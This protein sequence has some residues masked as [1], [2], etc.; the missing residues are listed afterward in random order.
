MRNELLLGLALALDIGTAN[1][2]PVP[3]GPGTPPVT[4]DGLSTCLTGNVLS[5][6]TT[7]TLSPFVFG[8]SATLNTK[9]ALTISGSFMHNLSVKASGSTASTITAPGGTL[10][11]EPTAT[12]SSVAVSTNAVAGRETCV[13]N[14]E[15]ATTVTLTSTTGSFF[16]HSAT[17]VAS[18][19]L[20]PGAVD[21]FESDGTN[22]Y[23]IP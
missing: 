19:T 15:T 23:Q 1:A 21:C 16:A 13:A 3:V 8:A 4:A 22:H 17:G 9:G 11:L 5:N 10:V 20:A 2:Q 7:V 12:T 6:C 14:Y 18:I